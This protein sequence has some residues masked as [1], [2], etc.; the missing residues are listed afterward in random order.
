MLLPR[1]SLPMDPISLALAPPANETPAQRKLR[2]AEEDEARKVS[3]RIDD[4]L[5]AE[6][7]ATKKNK[8]CVKVLVLG[9]SESGS[10]LLPFIYLPMD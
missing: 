10:Y 7:V 2:E 6:K 9:Q 3:Q 5:K 1:E 8:N 4:Q